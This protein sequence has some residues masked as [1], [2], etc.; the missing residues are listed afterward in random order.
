[1]HSNPGC[2]F[3]ILLEKFWFLVSLKLF[4]SCFGVFNL[5][6]SP[7]K[8]EWTTWSLHLRCCLDTV[9]ILHF[10]PL[11]T[12]Q[13]HSAPTH[14]PTP[15]PPAF[16]FINLAEGIGRYFSFI[17]FLWKLLAHDGG[18]FGLDELWFLVILE[19]HGPIHSLYVFLILLIF[20]IYDLQMLG[21]RQNFSFNF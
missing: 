8:G 15:Q 16:F 10:W 3:Y 5:L 9:F 11:K 20:L 18:R 12:P 2:N 14:S 1:M 13:K 6:P 4:L 7:R 19:V 21:M 17:I